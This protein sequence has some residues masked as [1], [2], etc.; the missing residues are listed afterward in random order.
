MKIWIVAV[1]LAGVLVATATAKAQQPWTPEE[2]KLFTSRCTALC[3]MEHT[4]QEQCPA[5]CACIRAKLQGYS[6][7]AVQETASARGGSVLKHP[8][9][10]SCVQ[11]SVARR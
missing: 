1:A 3:A 10:R 2:T 9:V 8:I 6:F 7:R 5:I 4:E 11:K